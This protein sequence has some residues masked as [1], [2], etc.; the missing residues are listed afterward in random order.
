MII[1]AHGSLGPFDE[2]IFLGTGLIFLGMMGLSW[3]R[4]RNEPIETSDEL[5]ESEKAP[6]QDAQEP[7]PE[8]FPLK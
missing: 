5:E 3:Y 8:R 7:T 4:S 2:L 1:L 6:E